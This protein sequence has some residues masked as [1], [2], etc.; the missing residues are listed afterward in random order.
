MITK[1]TVLVLG[2]G[3]SVPFGYP[4]GNTLVRLICDALRDQNH[5]H[6]KLL[7]KLGGR[8]DAVIAFRQALLYGQKNSVDA[9]LADRPDFLEIGKSSIAMTLMR[10]E[11]LEH[12]MTISLN[13]GSWYKYLFNMMAT[14]S[15]VEFGENNVSIITFNYDRS[16]EQ[17]LFTALKYS[18]D[19]NDSECADQVNR[20]PIV[21]VYGQLDPLPWQDADTGRAYIAS[22]D[23]ETVQKAGLGIKIM[24]EG[25]EFQSD[26]QFVHAHSLLV[27]AERIYFLGFGYH[28]DNM[29]RLNI[30]IASPAFLRGTAKGLGTEERRRAKNLFGTLK[31][32]VEFGNQEM[33]VLDFFREL[34]R[35]A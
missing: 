7:V 14:A 32:T 21:H 11:N 27:R 29:E 2:A 17:Y 26:P 31:N 4:S 5:S 1:P 18:Y 3:A 15:F 35:L 33:N 24:R 22:N 23:P 13:Q 6:F 10:H 34:A 30:E 25:Q 19:R 9:F 16:F 20:I 12:M 28:P 8:N